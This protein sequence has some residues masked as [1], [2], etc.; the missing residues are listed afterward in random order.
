MKSGLL[1][2]SLFVFLL[3]SPAAAQTAADRPSIVVTDVRVEPANRQ[4]Q[5]QNLDESFHS[6]LLVSIGDTR[7]FRLLDRDQANLGAILDEQALEASSLSNTSDARSGMVA[8]AG[9]VAVP[10]ITAYNSGASFTPLDAFPGRYD[11]RDYVRVE[12]SVRLL[13]SE[14]GELV[15]LAEASDSYSRMFEAVEGHTGAPPRSIGVNMM[16]GLA[17][18]LIDDV[19]N[20]AFPIMIADVSGEEVY[21]NRGGEGLSAGQRFHIYSQGRELIDP[22]TGDSMGASVE[23]R[24]GMI[25]ISRVENRFSVGRIVDGNAA[26]FAIGAIARHTNQ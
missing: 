17:N 26:D 25:E 9:F 22:I 23:R 24:V 21:L 13:H 14:T 1:R 16:G 5:Q 15:F 7:R 8:A 20:A 3:A 18:E 6:A 11:R 2:F 19:V 12:V 10:Y 4:V